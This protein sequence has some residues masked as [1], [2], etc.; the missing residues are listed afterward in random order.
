M[1]SLRQRA[2]L[3]G[4]ASGALSVGVGTLVVFSYINTRVLDQFDGALQDRHTQ[5]V[6]GLS[7]ATDDPETLRELIFDPAY[8]TPYSGRYWQVTDSN[9]AIYTS[10]SLFDET[11]AEPPRASG[12]TII[13]NTSGPD[14]EALRSAYQKIT[15]EDGTEWGVTVAESRS[16]LINERSAAQRN[17]LPVFGLVGLIGVA[18]SLL[19]MSAIVGPL[20]K[21]R[22]DVAHRWDQGDDLVPEDY[23]SEVSP[24]VEDLNQLLHR[25]R[26]IVSGSRKQAADLAHAL[27]TPATI[28]R[29]ELS[30]LSDAGVET[31]PAE[32]ALARIDAQLGRSLARMRA[33]NTGELTHSRTDLSN[34]VER[35]SRLFSVMAERDGK[36]LVSDCEAGLHVRMDPQDIEEVIGNLLDNALKWSRTTFQ[37]TARRTDNGIELCVEDDGPGIPESARDEAIRSGSRLDTSVMGTGLGLSISVDLLAAYGGKLE[38]GTSRRLGGLA[39][40][41][42]ITT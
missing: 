28:L 4:I 3:G 21:L 24:L 19:L 18:S 41:V 35:L 26:E 33:T 29:N 42:N 39:C 25:N 8:S 40:E 37:I 10:A 31:E 13:W 20:R 12:E 7:V 5:L 9:G 15:F 16:E 34:S 30:E 32:E 17:L 2:L 36:T 22:A 6:V 1:L 27:K 11:I 14:G 23:P 38:L